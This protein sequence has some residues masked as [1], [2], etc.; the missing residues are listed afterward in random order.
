MA[1]SGSFNT[2]AYNNRNIVFSWWVN[3]QSVS[4]DYTDIGWSIVG[5]GS[6]SGYYTSGNF[7]VIIDNEEVYFSSNRIN[8]YNG[9][10]IA[11]G[12]KRLYHDAAGNKSFSAY[13][14]AGIYYYAVNVSGSGSWS[15][16]QI[17]RYLNSINIYNNK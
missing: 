14:E 12:T 10:S 15:L 3:S 13:V 5:G 11:S 4:G 16:P 9:T 7:K 6:K 2:S 17:P 1:S 8:L